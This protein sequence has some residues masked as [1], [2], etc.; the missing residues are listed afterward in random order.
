LGVS[1]KTDKQSYQLSGNGLTYY[2][3]SNSNIS[4]VQ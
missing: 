1:K 2:D 4:Y 3:N